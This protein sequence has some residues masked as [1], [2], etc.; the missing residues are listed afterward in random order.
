GLVGTMIVNVIRL[1]TIFAVGSLFDV[2]AAMLIHRH[3]G[4]V[5]FVIW[6]FLLVLIINQTKEISFQRIFDRLRKL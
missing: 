3:L 4:D 2:E 5:I 1:M 6:I